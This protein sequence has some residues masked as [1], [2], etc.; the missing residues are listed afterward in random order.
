VSCRGPDRHATPEEIDFELASR[1]HKDAAEAN[2]QRSLVQQSG[3]EQE[4]GQRVVMVYELRV[5]F[6]G[7]RWIRNGKLNG[8]GD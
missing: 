5:D 3:F 1:K 6:R 7:F 4:S 8:Q 2:S